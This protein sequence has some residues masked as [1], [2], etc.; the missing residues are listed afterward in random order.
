ME[1]YNPKKNKY[2]MEARDYC[3][4]PEKNKCHNKK[5][6]KKDKSE[7]KCECH[8]KKKD[9]KNKSESKCEYD[10]KKKDKLELKCKVK[11]HFE[12]S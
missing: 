12:L 3:P 9:K 5:K 10:N 1:L 11:Y 2:Y 4:D 7:L 6:D 8:N